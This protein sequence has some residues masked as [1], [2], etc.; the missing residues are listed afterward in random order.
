[1]N[2]SKGG[3]MQI[4]DLA[5]KADVTPRTIRY[6]EELGI[7]EPEERTAGGFRLYSESQLRRLQIV[8]SLKDLGFGLDRIREFFNIKNGAESG[9]GVARALVEHLVEQERHIDDRI[10]QYM[11]MKE[12]NK[13]AIE[14]L[15]GCLCCTVKACERD[16][17]HC[18]VYREHE[19][20]PDLIECAIYE[21]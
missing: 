21:S 13:K 20:V 14:V 4:G 18:E 17:H 1:M 11:L 2:C 6:Y 8:Q 10:R 9:G 12:R 16:C 3:L 7:V 5:A 15:N 19:E